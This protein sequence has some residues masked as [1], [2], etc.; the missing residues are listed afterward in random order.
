MIVYLV[1]FENNMNFAYNDAFVTIATTNSEDLV[2]FYSRLL[3]QKPFPYIPQ[4]YAEFKLKRLRLGIFQ[5]KIERQMEFANSQSSSMSICLEVPDLELAI[6]HL[7]AIG[8]PPSGEII[9]ASHGREIYSYDPK[10]NRLILHQ[11]SLD[12]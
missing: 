5:P 9:T 7:R 4:V 8:Y 11:S 1:V 10:G 12:R 6:A 3:E 2:V